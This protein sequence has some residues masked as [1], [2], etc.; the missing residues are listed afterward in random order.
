V[1]L[2]PP[3]HSSTTFSAGLSSLEEPSIPG[4]FRPKLLTARDAEWALASS[5]CALFS[6]ALNCGNSVRIWKPVSDQLVKTRPA[7]AEFAGVLSSRECLK[8]NCL[9]P[10]RWPF[11][12]GRGRSASE[13]ARGDS[14]R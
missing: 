11:L 14:G 6:K 2:P 1:P 4:V 8:S 12:A 3:T 9:E 13:G 5:F 10:S 7:L